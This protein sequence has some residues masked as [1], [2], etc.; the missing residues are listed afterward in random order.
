MIVDE[1]YAKQKHLHVGDT[2]NLVNHEWKIGGDLRV[3][4]AGAHLREAA[5]AAGAD[6]ES[7]AI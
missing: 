3:G 7:R 6:G 1:Y 5:G 4:Q 2:V